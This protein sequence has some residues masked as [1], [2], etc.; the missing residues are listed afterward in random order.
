VVIGKQFA[1]TN[2]ISGTSRFY[3]LRKPL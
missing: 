1:I 2:T 3:R